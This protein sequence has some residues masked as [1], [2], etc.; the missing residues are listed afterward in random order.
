MPEGHLTTA[1]RVFA[2][3]SDAYLCSPISCQLNVCVESSAGT[4]TALSLNFNL[5]GTSEQ[6]SGTSAGET[7]FL[8]RLTS[9]TGSRLQM[10][11]T[12]CLE[13]IFVE[14]LT[15]L[16]HLLCASLATHN[17]IVR[18]IVGRCR[19]RRRACIIVMAHAYYHR[20]WKLPHSDILNLWVYTPS[21]L[22]QCANTC[23]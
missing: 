15:M 5:A 2:G 22:H 23:C 10:A 20:L 3:P 16:K 8:K 11:P 1:I 12:T 17:L 21:Q 14:R 9:S 4:F 6:F 18:G 7:C 19:A 13:G